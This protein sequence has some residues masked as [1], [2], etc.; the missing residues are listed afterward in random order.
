MKKYMLLTITLLLFYST[1]VIL[2]DEPITASTSEVQVVNKEIN[3]TETKIDDQVEKDLQ[4]KED[5]T[6][7]L[8]NETQQES[9]SH[10]DKE[11]K[12]ETSDES[13]EVTIEDYEKNV[14]N[15]RKIGIEQLMESFQP[16]T[17]GEAVLYIGRPTCRHCRQF[18]STLKELNQLIDG[19]LSYYNVD[20]DDFDEKAREF[21]FQT[22]GVPGTPTL[23]HMK[24][25]KPIGAFV[26][27]GISVQELYK[28][29]YKKEPPTQSEIKSEEVGQESDVLSE[30]Q[31]VR[32]QAISEV[33]NAQH[34]VEL[35][36]L[37]NPEERQSTLPSTYIPIKQTPKPESLLT[38]SNF[39][40]H[41]THWNRMLPT[42][43]EISPLLLQM[44]GILAFSGGMGI[45]QIKYRIRKHDTKIK[46]LHLKRIM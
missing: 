43:G 15:F 39:S 25:G 40:M 18:S 44:L 33:A 45:L 22:L 20:G 31:Q 19:K 8:L 42:T 36:A 5:K 34:Q 16:D 17:K 28:A 37:P 13:K 32:T 1:E 6:P 41:S 12:E 3:R 4:N 24:E 35:V 27:G 7:D 21:I 14:A 29:L 26:G 23:I 30:D 10:K 2:A 11:H 46:N 9:I 38:V